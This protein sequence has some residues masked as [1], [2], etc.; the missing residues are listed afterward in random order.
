MIGT[1][2]E[3]L[4]I[5]VHASNHSSLVLLEALG[6][7]S[8][9]GPAA[10]YDEQPL[11]LGE[12]HVTKMAGPL[13]DALATVLALDP[14]PQRQVPK[15]RCRLAERRGQP[16]GEARGRLRAT[17]QLIEHRGD[18]P[19]VDMTGRTFVRRSEPH[20]ADPSAFHPWRGSPVPLEAAIVGLSA[21]TLAVRD[22]DAMAHFLT[23][24]LGFRP[25]P[26][27]STLFETGGGGPGAQARVLTDSNRGTPGAGGVHHVAWSVAD[28]KELLAWQE[29]IEGFRLRTSGLVDRHYFQSLYFRIPEGILFELATE[30]PGFTADGEALEHLGEKLS[31]PP[32][33][34]P[35]RAEIEAG[36]KP[37]ALP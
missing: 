3:L 6:Q 37:L 34:E 26:S 30:G 2:T 22:S 9:R 13:D 7:V 12:Q 25:S 15:Q 21:V 27:D 4:Q 35:R 31:L 32:F 19:A 10:G 1:G 14:R 23:E 11:S 33:L 20:P 17:Q 5:R 28:V 8:D 29:R 24:I 18:E 36:L 16:G